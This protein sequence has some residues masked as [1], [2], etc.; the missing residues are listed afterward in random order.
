MG[1]GGMNVRTGR[2][3]EGLQNAIFSERQPLHS[4]CTAA[5]VP[6][7]VPLTFGPVNAHGWG[8]HS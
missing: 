5:E 8:R 6:T 3:A 2:E 7:L 4:Q 1:G